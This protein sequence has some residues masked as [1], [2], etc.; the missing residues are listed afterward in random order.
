MNQ[1]VFFKI[2][3]FFLL[4][5]SGDRTLG[6]ISKTLYFNQKSGQSHN[7]NHVL[8]ESTA[9]V[10]IFGNSRAQ[11]HYD[12]SVLN[13]SLK[14]SCF[15]AGIDGGHSI[16]LP[17]AEIQVVLNRYTP[18]LIILEFDPLTL[19]NNKEDYDK[20]S[21]L[22]PYYEE[23]PLIRPIIETRNPFE[24]LKLIS[25][26]YPYNSNIINLVRFN[27]IKTDSSQNDYQGFVPIIK[28]IRDPKSMEMDYAQITEIDTTKLIALQ[29]IIRICKGTGTKLVIANSPKY[30]RDG[31][32]VLPLPEYAVNCINMIKK[33]G[34]P[35]LD[36]SYDSIFLNKTDWFADAIHLNYRGAAEY[37]REISGRI[38]LIFNSNSK[39]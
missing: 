34:I 19:R 3:V 33:E 30:H 36:F 38:L 16:L 2:L 9:E 25:A 35:Y 7:L 20:L 18:R 4:V 12:V 28:V 39:L 26:L 5:I 23:Y 17:Y 27:F 29:N 22:L 10:L 37:S 14:L 24:P 1:S 15:N 8:K 6:W 13:Q 11:H 21:V 32:E 31:Q